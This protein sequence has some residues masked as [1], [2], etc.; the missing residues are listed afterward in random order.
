MT[1]PGP[2]QAAAPAAGRP[3]L[4]LGAIFKNEGP[5]ILEWIAFHRAVGVTRFFIADNGSDDGSGE[6]LAALDR[7]G[8]IRHIPFPGRPGEPPQLPA[9]TEI[10]RRHGAEADWIA[11]IDA[12][13]FLQPAPPERSL[14]PTLAALDAAA[15][16]GMFV[17]NWAVYGSSGETEA[18]PEPVIERFQG[19]ARRGAGINRR[20]K[21]VVRVGACAGTSDN[22]HHFQLLPGFR[23][24]HVDGTDLELFRP[25]RSGMSREVRWSP[26]RLNH[27][28]VKS[29]QEFFE[30][31][32]PR[33]RATKADEVR[34]TSFF[35]D[36]DRNEE[37][38]PMPPW[39]IAAVRSGKS[40]ILA[41]LRAIGWTAGEPAVRPGAPRP[42]APRG[43]ARAAAAPSR[44]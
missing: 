34:A 36:H 32:L 39:L 5:Y 24:V 38:A 20:Y 28:V 12:D 7:A 4:A 2:L 18:R 14:I 3:V 43:P 1:D 27:Y 17:V 41:E 13:E 15:D 33:G 40:R 25:A 22:P 11:F 42:A 26:M 19:R 35:D 44:R 16:V 9:Y 23:A 6:L 37:L 8:V 31:K 21:S 10:L 30:R 29:R